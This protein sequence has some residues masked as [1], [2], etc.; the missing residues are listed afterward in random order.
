MDVKLVMFKSDGQRKDFP[1]TGAVT[2]LG[3]GEECDLRVPLLNVSRKHC[4][5]TCGG[6]QLKV[7][8][9]GSSNGTYVNN[10]RVTEVVLKA[11]D[12]LAIGPIVFTV[13]LDGKPEQIRPVKMK[14]AEAAKSDDAADVAEIVELDAAE[15]AAADAVDDD[16]LAALEAMNAPE[17]KKK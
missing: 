1:V 14:A 7:K 11:G 4:E 15:P 2:V 9:L 17:K 13:Q 8:D 10:R 12:R 3:R 6:S 5:L 16:V